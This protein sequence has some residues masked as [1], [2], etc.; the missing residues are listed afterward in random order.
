MFV[1]QS[2]IGDT[3][4]ASRGGGAP[5]SRGVS[6]WKTIA[7]VAEGGRRGAEGGGTKP[8]GSEDLKTSL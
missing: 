6:W 5:I 2:R 4:D 7:E 8:Y 1:G 3:K